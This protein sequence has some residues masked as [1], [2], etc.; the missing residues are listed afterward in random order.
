MAKEAGNRACVRCLNWTVTPLPARFGAGNSRVTIVA[1]TV[2]AMEGSREA[3]LEAGMDDHISKPVK[4]N[5]SF[6]MYST[7]LR[8]RQR[9]GV[10]AFEQGQAPTAR[11]AKVVEL[12]L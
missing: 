10:S 1:M 3:C 5:E 6:P 4:R 2:E 8:M 11:E 12:S 7:S 9:S